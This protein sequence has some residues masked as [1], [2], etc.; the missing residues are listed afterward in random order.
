MLVG[1]AACS[2]DRDYFNP[3]EALEAE[4]Q[5]LIRYYNE[6]MGNGMTR[7]DSMS[8]AAVDTVDHR[9][10]SGLMLFHTKIGEGD[11]V[12][13]FKKVGYRF[14]AY[15]IKQDTLDVTHEVYQGS[16]EYA[17]SPAT[18]RTFL[19]NDAQTAGNEKVPLGINEALL[20][21]CFKGKSKIVLPSTIAGSQFEPYVYEIEVTYLE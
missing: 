6:P 7:L 18:Y 17:N 11:S 10:E 19:I 12:K 21:M 3:K 9:L 14:T 4:K 20:H 2:E 15:K 5:L 16:N 8:A 1:F 13:L